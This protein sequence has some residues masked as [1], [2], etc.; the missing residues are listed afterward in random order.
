MTT[1]L[2]SRLMRRAVTER[3]NAERTASKPRTPRIAACMI[4]PALDGGRADTQTRSA[5]P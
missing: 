3:V 1:F 4:A 5:P 2:H